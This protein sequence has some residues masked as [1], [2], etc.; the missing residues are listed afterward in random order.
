MGTGS[1]RGVAMTEQRQGMVK[2]GIF[3]SQA[4]FWI[5]FFP[6]QRMVH[7]YRVFEAQRL[8]EHEKLPLIAGK[9]ANGE[10]TGAGYLVKKLLPFIH[11]ANVPAQYVD[12]VEWRVLN[13]RDKGLFGERVVDYLIED[14]IVKFPSRKAC[15]ERTKEGQYAGI[16]GT[17]V[18]LPAWRWETKTECFASPNLYVQDMERGHKVFQVR[19][20]SDQPHEYFS[21]IDGFDNGGKGNGNDRT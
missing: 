14:Q 16:D 18:Y 13:D 20:G 12:S 8:I 4:D 5:H 7:W 9:S 21:P 10:I 11:S 3:T 2:R 19:D 15:H 1:R 6:I 17:L